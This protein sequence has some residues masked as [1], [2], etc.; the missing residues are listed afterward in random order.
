VAELLQLEQ[1]P[2]DSRQSVEGRPR[3]RL[4]Y[5]TAGLQVP[6]LK[7]PVVPAPGDKLPFLPQRPLAVPGDQDRH[8]ARRHGHAG[9]GN[10]NGHMIAG[11]R[12]GEATSVEHPFEVTAVSSY[13]SR[14][15]EIPAGLTLPHNPGNPLDPRNPAIFMLGTRPTGRGTEIAEMAP[16]CCHHG[17]VL[18][19]PYVTCGWT[20]CGC[21]GHSHWICHHPVEGGSRC[22]DEV[23]WPPRNAD[24]HKIGNYGTRSGG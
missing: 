15:P 22:G 12:Y 21:G 23:L 4:T 16:A 3:A 8:L 6:Q 13:R 9:H 19:Y 20:P 5:P 17:H 14:T 7:V 2:H 10:H 24:C 18:A 11:Q 1:R